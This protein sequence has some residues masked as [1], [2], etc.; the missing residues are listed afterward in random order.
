MK[1]FKLYM[2][3]DSHYGEA[4]S[5]ALEA[6]DDAAII[7][8]MEQFP[9]ARI[10]P[11]YHSNRPRQWFVS[12]ADIGGVLVH[13]GIRS[14]GKEP[15]VERVELMYSHSDPREAVQRMIDKL[16]LAAARLTADPSQW[17][18]DTDPDHHGRDGGWNHK[19]ESPVSGPHLH[20]VNRLMLC[21][22]YCTDALQEKLDDGWRL[23]A[24]CPQEN[25]RPDYVLGRCT[26]NDKFGRADR[27]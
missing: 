9:S 12:D 7:S 21:E 2:H 1:L 22:D 24:V 26:A 25:R 23:V 11:E 18:M 8:G 20:S 19:T 10:D 13:F 5:K 17:R 27:G 4:D 16:E 15:G 3:L 6:T 14:Y